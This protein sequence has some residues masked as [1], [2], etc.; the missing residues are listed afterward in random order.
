MDMFGSSSQPAK[1]LTLDF[2]YPP[3]KEALNQNTKGQKGGQGLQVRAVFRKQDNVSLVV[4]LEITN[5]QQGQVVADLDLMFNKNPFGIAIYNAGS[6]FSSKA[7]AIHP[8]QT[9]S[10]SL[11]CVID[12]KNLDPKNPPK[13]P[14]MVEAALKSSID[15]FYFTIHCMLHCLID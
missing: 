6:V 15:V 4:D 2:A 14:F 5:H 3:L 9:V 8:G 7:A 1:Q 13:S 10:Y 11:P 12:K